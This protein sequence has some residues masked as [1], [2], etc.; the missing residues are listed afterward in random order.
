MAIDFVT[1]EVV[2][3]KQ[4]TV[5]HLTDTMEPCSPADAAI[6]KVVFDEG[7][8]LFG[9]RKPDGP[10]AHRNLNGDLEWC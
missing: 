5:S 1:R 9:V 8:V 7:G 3:G 4:A 10:T 2:D 6:V